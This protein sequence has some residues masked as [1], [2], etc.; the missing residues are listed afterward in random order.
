MKQYT[1]PKIISILL[2]S[3]FFCSCK[4]DDTKTMK[5]FGIRAS[6]LFLYYEH[7]DAATD[8]YTHTLGMELVSDYQMAKI[9]RM[10]ADSY[11]I[12]V[13][14]ASGMHTAKEPKTVAL[15]LISD[16][17]E[18][19]Y[20]F[21]KTQNVEIKY[22][23]KTKEGSP[24]D[25]FVLLDPEGYLL[26]FERFNPH[27]ENEDF[28]PLLEQAKTITCPDSQN[29]GVPAG[30]GFKATVTWLY[31]KDLLAMQTFYLDVLGL[32]MVADQG[33][34]KIHKSSSTGF[35]GLVDEKKG[36]HN[37]TEEKAVNVSFILDELEPWFD[38]AKNNKLFEMRSGKLET[39]PET[40]YKAFVGYD[41]EGYFMEFDRFYTHADNNL[42]MKYL[43]GGEKIVLAADVHASTLATLSGGGYAQILN[44]K[45]FNDDL[46]RIFIQK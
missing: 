13:D 31:Y 3:L 41:P 34:T 30:L 11:L 7:L 9:L 15:A 37:F 8:F 1:I 44:L 25:G 40:K 33:W 42:L 4:T 16:Q 26:E 43:N 38:Y 22:E 23:L 20:A 39:G 32:E 45:E 12:L 17:L 2:L 24:H 18:E 28:M 46:T 5:D 6:N 36:M 19:W 29:S 10:T 21:L 27:P 14:A 35:I